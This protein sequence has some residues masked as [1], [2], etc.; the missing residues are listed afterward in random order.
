MPNRSKDY[1]KEERKAN[2]YQSLHETVY[3]EGD[4]PVEVQIRTHKMH[5]SGWLACG[6]DSPPCCMALGCAVLRSCLPLPA[7]SCLE[8]AKTLT[9]SSPP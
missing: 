1:I 6:A 5:V 4:L 8:S 9:I 7:W 3:G 2:G